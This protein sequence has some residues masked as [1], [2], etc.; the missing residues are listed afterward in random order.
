MLNHLSLVFDLQ[1]EISL[2]LLRKL[3]YFRLRDVVWHVD[4]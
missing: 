2:L 3:A 4:I 1:E